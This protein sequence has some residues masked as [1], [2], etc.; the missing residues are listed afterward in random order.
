[1]IQ[2][3]AVD[4]LVEKIGSKY[5]LCVVT[6]KRAR[7]LIDQAHNQGYNDI[8]GKYKAITLAAKEIESGKIVSAND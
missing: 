6:A 4:F 2:E 3:P 8:P 5:G 1:M 7:Q